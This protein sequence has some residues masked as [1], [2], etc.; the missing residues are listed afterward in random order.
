M[1]RLKIGLVALALLVAAVVLYARGPGGSTA[2]GLAGACM[3]VGLVLG[4][5]WLAMPQIMRFF[6]RTPRWLLTAGVIAL[7]VC[8]VKPMLLIFAI[9]LLGLLW[10]LGPKLA[11]KADKPIAPPAPVR[12]PRRRSNAR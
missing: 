2:N 7:I 9:P 3:K 10:F 11:T 4:A 6:S 1:N 8:V 12:R 5:L